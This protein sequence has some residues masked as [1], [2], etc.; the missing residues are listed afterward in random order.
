MLQAIR[1]KAT[2]WIAYTILTLLCIPFALWGI[3]A[4]FGGGSIPDVAEVN[5][6]SVSQQQFQ[7]AYQ[8]QMAR[9]SAI[10]GDTSSLDTKR[11]KE[12]VLQQLVNQSVLEQA[13][14]NAGL[15]VGNQQLRAAIEHMNAFQKNGHFNAAQ[16]QRVL[17]QQGY[18][19]VSFEQ[20]MR[21]SLVTDQLQQGLAGTAFVT[22]SDLKHYVALQGQQRRLSYLVLPLAHY[23]KQVKLTDQ[24]IRQYY[25]K[26]KD[27]YKS[28]EQV[29][30]QYLQLDLQALTAKVKVTEAQLKAAYQQRLDQYTQPEQRRASYIL[31]K[32]PTGASKE[33]VAKARKRAEA[34]YQQIHAGSKTFSEEVKASAK[35]AG[36]EGGDLGLVSGGTT[37]PAFEKALFALAKKGDISAPVK[38]SY[39]FQIIRLDGIV[40][41]HVSPFAKVRSD[42][43][44]EL[45]QRKARPE[46]YDA[47]EK[48]A[49][50]TFEHPDSLQRAAKALDLKIQ[51]TGWISRKGSHA[52][53]IAQYP[54]VLKTAFS[55]AVLKDRQNSQA[56]QV[57]PDHVIV[58]HLADHKPAAPLPFA[59]ARDQV[60]AQLTTDRARHALQSDLDKLIKQ[61]RAGGTSLAA[62]A[63]AHDAKLEQAGL[64]GRNDRK[65]EQAVLTNAFKLPE[66][67]GKHGAVY[68]KATLGNGDE[69]LIAVSEVVPGKLDALDAK[70]RKQLRQ[71]LVTQIGNQQFRSFV[72]SQRQQASVKVNKAQLQ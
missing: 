8:Q 48:L 23:K 4:Y 69:A 32:T 24:E 15:R 41:K 1:D 65:V 49:N 3:N 39:G 13:S 71:Q 61:A 35:E 44:H 10:L 46:F 31:V 40:P 37:D 6:K 9:L 33:A 68:G 70:Q 57:A 29:K 25:D 7:Q 51:Q 64:V 54:K 28:P 34:I 2:G 20:K 58:I 45:R 52:K 53:G 63:K 67:Q 18:R 56:L 5:G 14:E 21:Q 43:E 59:K 38:T 11:L 36:V 19:P 12:R 66:P 62:L 16:Y 55:S 72:F 27:Q 60:V 50:L 42:L 47:S 30:L 22:D 26:H 17:E